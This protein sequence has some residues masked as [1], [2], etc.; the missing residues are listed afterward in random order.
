MEQTSQSNPY[1]IPGAIVIAGLF[2]AGAIYFAFFT[3]TPD[4][5]DSKNGQKSGQETAVRPVD[6]TDFI[7]GNPEA[8]VVVLEY[9]DFECPFCHQFHQSMKQLMGQYGESG[10]VAWVFR[11]FPLEQ[12]HSKA[13][14]EALA[15]ECAAAQGGNKAFWDYA[16]KLF[17]GPGNNQL[18]LAKL[19]VFAAD[20]GLDR[21]KFEACMK[22]TS[23]DG[24]MKNVTE[25]FNGAVKAGGQGTPFTMILAN[26]EVHQLGGALP[27]PALKAAVDLFVKNAEA[28]GK[29]VPPTTN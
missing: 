19:P 26:G 9:S 25:D 21:A 18:D 3:K 10:K 23:E 2:I 24:L 1:L 5:A 6:G 27:Y 28:D 12:L 11:Q 8:P 29:I 15:S 17:S 4:R 7:L 13:P 16:D 14:T 22:D 20:I